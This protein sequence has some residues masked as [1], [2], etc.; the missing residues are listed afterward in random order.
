MLFK[1]NVAVYCENRTKHKNT[2]CGQNTELK[3]IK[4]SDTNGTTGF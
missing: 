4:A 2:F 1:E 3:Y